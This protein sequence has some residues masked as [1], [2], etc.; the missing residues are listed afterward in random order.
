MGVLT[1]FIKR[2][3]SP[4]KLDYDAL[5]NSETGEYKQGYYYGN[6]VQASKGLFYQGQMILPCFS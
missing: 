6:I 3:K 1:L 4:L 5:D 2:K